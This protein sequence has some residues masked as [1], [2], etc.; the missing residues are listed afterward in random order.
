MSEGDDHFEGYPGWRVAAP[1][2][3][4]RLIVQD[5]EGRPHPGGKWGEADS[6]DFRFVRAGPVFLPHSVVVHRH[7]AEGGEVDGD[8]EQLPLGPGDDEVLIDDF[9]A[10]VADILV[11]ELDLTVG[12]PVGA[13]DA[14]N[15]ERSRLAGR[16]QVGDRVES[17][18]EGELEDAV[19]IDVDAPGDGGEAD[20]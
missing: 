10:A 16:E 14:E 17:D 12:E 9:P 18:G 3:A 4:S 5:A 20:G 19:T 1:E 2:D 7:G 13:I 15:P 6:V 11:G 8:C